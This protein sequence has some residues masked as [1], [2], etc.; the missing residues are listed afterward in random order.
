[1]QPWQRSVDQ[2]A[3]NAPIPLKQIIMQLTKCQ[4]KTMELIFEYVSKLCPLVANMCVS[5]THIFNFSHFFS[6][7]SISERGENWKLKLLLAGW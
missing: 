1:M 2:V 7:N 3:E 6:N 5:S 4:K